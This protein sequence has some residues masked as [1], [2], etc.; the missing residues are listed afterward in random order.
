MRNAELALNRRVIWIVAIVVLAT[1]LAVVGLATSLFFAIFR[2][3]DG[4]G[5]HVC[6]MAIVRRSDAAARLVGTPIEQQGLTGGSTSTNNAELTER[7]TF[8]VKGP[9]GEAFVV[10]QGRRSQLD[11]HLDVRIGRNGQSQTI[12]SGPFDCPELHRAGR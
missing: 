3:M 5:A 8:T 10:S 4:A 7:I 11:S 9:L 12:Y 1:M 2:A 6:G